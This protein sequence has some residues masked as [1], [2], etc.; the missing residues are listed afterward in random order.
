MTGV[1]IE[2]IE[3]VSDNKYRF[4][5]RV[6]LMEGDSLTI[7]DCLLIKKP[8]REGYLVFPPSRA[9]LGKWYEEVQW[10]NWLR[11]AI[12]EAA[13]RELQAM[14]ELEANEAAQ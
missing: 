14:N 7:F 10:P 1:K 8:N 13:L 3:R 5:V 12:R 6:A 4:V 9:Q 2:K 11:N